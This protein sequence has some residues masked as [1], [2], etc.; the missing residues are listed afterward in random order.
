[1]R[2]RYEFLGLAY[3]N[4]VAV[5]EIKRSDYAVRLEELQRLEQYKERLLRGRSSVY[6]VMICNSL[7]VSADVEDSWKKRQDGDIRSWSDIYERVKR[8]YEHYRAVLRSAV[9]H[10]DFSAK[11]DEIARTREVLQTGS[12][13]RGARARASGLGPQDID[14]TTDAAQ[15]M[16]RDDRPE[17]NVDEG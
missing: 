5:I 14:Y 13:F 3:A 2:Q 15:P 12:A 10:P 6:M 1:M 9:E 11:A 7:Q 4:H 17:D 8:H 16:R